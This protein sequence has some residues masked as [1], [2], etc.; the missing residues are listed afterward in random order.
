MTG[1]NLAL[2]NEELEVISR[3]EFV[4]R[5]LRGNMPAI[6]AC[7]A[8]GRALGLDDMASLRSIHIVDG[9]AT[10]SAELMVQLV[11]KAGHSITGEFADGSSTVR[12]RRAD[13]GDEMAVTW[14]MA[15]AE[16]AGLAGKANWKKYPES[17]LWARAV[18]Q[19]C[20]MLF[21]DCFAGSTYTP[22]EIGAELTSAEGEPV[23]AVLVAEDDGLFPPPDAPEPGPLAEPGP[24]EVGHAGSSDL[25]PGS[26]SGKPLTA[27]QAKKLNV[28]VG[29]LRDK[30]HIST[31]HL[32]RVVG[33]TPQPGEDGDMH[34][35][36][37]RDSLTRDEASALIERLSA[38]EERVKAEGS[39][40]FAIPESAQAALRGEERARAIPW[41]REHDGGFRIEDRL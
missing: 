9:Q 41:L 36:P 38:L 18:S 12:G 26:A 11:R 28:L 33:R 25:L 31:A 34:W 14:T 22:E 17:M 19:L 8:T 32:Y 15:M 39:G 4:P 23:E 2:R 29:T 20:R 35:S 6:L 7:V 24:D 30:G 13:N 27:A 21:A 40:G 16:R 10:F 37:L 3:T 1:Q 5:G